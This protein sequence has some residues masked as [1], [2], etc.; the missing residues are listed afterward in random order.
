MAGPLA[1]FSGADNWVEHPYFNGIALIGDAAATSDPCWG[2][3][4]SL[5]LRDVRVLRDALI[6]DNDWDRAG[7]AY[8]AQ[9]DHYY[10]AVHAYEDLLTEFFYGTSPEA[11]ARRAKAMP[12]ISEDPSRIPDYIFSGPEITFDESMRARFFGDA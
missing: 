9:H 1:T 7:H 6:A 5:T 2:Q 11:H 4:L 3:G 12:L 10:H 8:A